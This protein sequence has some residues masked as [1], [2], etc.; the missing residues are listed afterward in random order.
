MIPWDLCLR[1]ACCVRACVRTMC[2]HGCGPRACVLC[3]ELH[4]ARCCFH[5]GPWR[6]RAGTL[7]RRRVGWAQCLSFLFVLAPSCARTFL[8]FAPCHPLL[9]IPHWLLPSPHPAPPCLALPCPAPPHLPDH[10]VPLV[11]WELQT[12]GA[13]APRSQTR[14]LLSHSAW[15]L[16][17]WGQRMAP[18]WWRSSRWAPST[19]AALTLWAGCGRLGRKCVHGGGQ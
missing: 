12:A 6:Q 10:P 16:R 13:K 8:R 14:A 5:V 15:S 1:C 2:S 4:R 18:W 11:S 9:R 17:R 19:L 3:L 7:P